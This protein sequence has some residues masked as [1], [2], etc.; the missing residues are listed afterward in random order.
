M[1][2]HLALMDA[3]G[4]KA[5]GFELELPGM[6]RVGDDVVVKEEGVPPRTFRVKKVVWEAHSPPEPSDATRSVLIYVLAL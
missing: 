6:P 5:K 2:V 1:K 4:S 3:E